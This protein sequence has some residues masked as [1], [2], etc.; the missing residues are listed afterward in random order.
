MRKQRELQNKYKNH[1]DNFS[2]IAHIIDKRIEAYFYQKVI[3]R[4][5]C[6]LHHM[7]SGD[8]TAGD[9]AYHLLN[10][11]FKMEERGYLFYDSKVH[12]DLSGVILD[13]FHTNS[14]DEPFTFNLKSNESL[15]NMSSI[16]NDTDNWKFIQKLNHLLE[17][18]KSHAVIEYQV[19]R[20]AKEHGVDQRNITIKTFYFKPFATVYTVSRVPKRIYQ[21]IND[22]QVK[23]NQEF[24]RRGDIHVHPVLKRPIFDIAQF[25]AHGNKVFPARAE[26]FQIGPLGRTKLYIQPSGWSRFGLRV[27]NKYPGNKQWLEPFGHPENWYRAFHGTGNA[28]K[29]DFA[30]QHPESAPNFYSVAAIANIHENGFCVA[31]NAAHGCGV[32]CSPDPKFPENGYVKP[33]TID[34]QRGQKTF[35]VMLQVAVNPDGVKFATN[36]IWVVPNPPDIRAY[37]VLIKE[38]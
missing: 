29:Q 36:D 35:K 11:I 18:N 30:G 33:V 24:D 8:V 7:P 10:Q 17:Q 19:E 2:D 9:T 31:R 34:T 1:Y 23:L 3:E 13:L 38:V 14:N 22:H 21:L 12:I 5:N 16:I 28:K 4:S 20:L 15:G 32:Y 26:T 37:G 6:I 25:D 27:L